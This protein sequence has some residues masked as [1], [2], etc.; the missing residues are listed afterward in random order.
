MNQTELAFA[1]AL[2]Q[3]QLI[4]DRVISPLELTQLYLDRISQFDA[5][6]GSY[7][8]VATETALADA[9]AKTEQLTKISDIQELPP[10]FGV[11]IPV[12]DLYPVL[13]MPCSYGVAALKEQLASYDDG[14]V[15][16][17][18]AAG[19][20]ILGKTAASQL[21]ALPYTEP[22]GFNPTR[23]PW[24]LDYTSGG[25]SGGAASAVAAGLCAIAHGSDGGGSVR[26]PAACCGL[27]GIKPSRGRV[28]NAPVGDYQNGIATHGVLARTVADAAALLQVMSGYNL[29]DPYWLPQPE[30][31]FSQAAETTP[32]PLKIGL[33]TEITPIGKAD[34][35]YEQ[36]LR[37]QAEQ[38]SSL[39]HIITE[40]IPDLTGL[41][42]PFVRVWSAGVAA[43]TIPNSVLSPLNQW[44]RTQSGTAGEYLQAVMQMQIV[45]RQIV[46]LLTNIDVLLLPVYMHPPIKVGAWSQLTYEAT[47][48]KIINWVAPCPPANAAGLPAIALP[49]AS[50]DGHGL[51]ISIQLIGKP[52]AETTLISL[53]A[54]MEVLNPWLKQR[55]PFAC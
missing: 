55:P 40:I 19:F 38:L 34:P 42:K 6:L 53:A 13:G 30:I 18:K 47:L 1:P 28:S 16:R 24:N 12:K 17:L 39:G 21:G 7:Y 27:V 51:P 26:G 44:L 49:T 2:T 23:N 54:Q 50:F 43:N 33:I 48:E 25:S 32:S 10:F 3:A 4:R 46:S 37:D 5:E 52:A 11:P 35:V 15:Y 8:H 36:V 9:Q 31:S 20:T 45:S 14:I 22:E 29:G 41:I